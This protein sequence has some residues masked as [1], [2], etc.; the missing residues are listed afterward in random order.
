MS[1]CE[2]GEDGG[3]RGEKKYIK[4]A[5]LYPVC[6][7]RQRRKKKIERENSRRGDSTVRQWT[8]AGGGGVTERRCCSQQGNREGEKRR[9]KKKVVCLQSPA[10]SVGFKATSCFSCFIRLWSQKTEKEKKKINAY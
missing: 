2:A 10:M 4:I 6:P 7:Q 8:A 3:G 9:G 1:K 5:R